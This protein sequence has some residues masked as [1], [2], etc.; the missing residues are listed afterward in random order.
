MCTGSQ[1]G[2]RQLSKC[3]ICEKEIPEEQ[4]EFAENQEAHPGILGIIDP[5][6]Y[7]KVDQEDPALPWTDPIS[8]ELDFEEM[9]QDLSVS[10][11]DEDEEDFL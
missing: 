2:V 8:G 6:C 4:R 5:E 11:G 3:Q 1:S 9:E 7:A 10:T